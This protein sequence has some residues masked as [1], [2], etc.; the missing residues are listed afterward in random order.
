M[1]NLV[2][3]KNEELLQIDG[4]GHWWCEAVAIDELKDGFDAGWVDGRNKNPF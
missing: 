4:G 1:E 3:L 2:E